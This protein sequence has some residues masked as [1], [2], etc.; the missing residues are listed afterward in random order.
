MEYLVEWTIELD[1]DTPLEAAEMAR[2]F[3]RDTS[4][5]CGVFKVYDERGNRTDIDLDEEELNGHQ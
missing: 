5:W 2:K 3:Q 1:A 4:A